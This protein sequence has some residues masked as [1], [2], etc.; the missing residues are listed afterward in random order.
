MYWKEPYSVGHW[1][2]LDYE[3]FDPDV[4]M[5]DD[6][7]GVMLDDERRDG[8]ATIHRRW[9]KVGFPYIHN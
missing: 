5:I 2:D 8:D 3:H 4:L 6:D 7:V 1:L 9:T